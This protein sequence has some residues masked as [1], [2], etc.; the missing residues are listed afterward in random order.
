MRSVGKSGKLTARK[1]AEAYAMRIETYFGFFAESFFRAIQGS[2]TQQTMTPVSYEGI[3]IGTTNSLKLRWGEVDTVILP[4]RVIAGDIPFALAL[5]ARDVQALS[6]LAQRGVSLQRLMEQAV[7]TAIEPFNLISKRRNRLTGLTFSHNVTGLTAAH[8]DGEVSY[9]VATGRFKLRSQ[10]EFALRLLVTAKGRD[11]IEDRATA[12]HT[13][14]ALFSIIEGAYVCSP[15]WEPLPPPP[16]AEAP[17]GLSERL[18][19]AWMQSFFALNGGAVAPRVFGQPVAFQGAL[20]LEEEL[21]ELSGESAP[22]TVVR[23]IANDKKELEALVVLRQAAERELIR[24]SKSAEPRFLGDLFRVLFG[25][26]AALWQRLARQDV[27]WK[28]LAV[29]RIP[30]DSVGAVSKRLEGGGMTLRLEAGLDEGA[31]FWHV[32]LPPH[33]WHWMMRLTAKAMEFKVGESPDRDAIFQATGWGSGTIPWKVVFPFFGD[34]DLQHLVRQLERVQL[35]EAD[36]AAIGKALRHGD[37]DRWLEA[38]PVNL[39][40]R[41]QEYRVAPGEGPRRQIAITEQ[42]IALNRMNRLPEGRLVPW[43]DVYA[44]F[45]WHRRQHLLEAQ[46]PLRH[47]VYGMDRGSLSRLL[48]DEKNQVLEEMLCWA[49]FPVLDQARRVIS[50]GF[51]LRLLD[52]IAHRRPR[53]CAFACQTAQLSVYRRAHQGRQHGRYLI[54]ETPAR[55]LREL[56]RWLD[57]P[58]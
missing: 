52:N 17:T 35:S 54:R 43:L 33:T 51:A 20:A 50:P 6:E 12:G 26:G 25:E 13:Q 41:V 3:E 8:L 16:A 56:I 10:S 4:E 21:E 46:L 5:T 34:R 18:S 23:L 53:T 44:E 7:S 32:A 42:L 58:E 47:L 36:L 1:M 37:R 49:E 28:V 45:Q 55:R 30:P 2:L 11:R 14:R 22:L 39:R 38:M 19:A 27:T 9:T 57:E 48:Y 40:E 31:L 24:L 29:G 15:Q